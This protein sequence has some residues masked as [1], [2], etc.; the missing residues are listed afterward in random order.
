MANTAN[1][2]LKAAP[3]GCAVSAL[4]VILIWAFRGLSLSTVA[5]S[6]I[7]GILAF[8]FMLAYWRTKIAWFCGMPFVAVLVPCIVGG[9]FWNI[10]SGILIALFFQ[11]M[12][13]LMFGRA[14]V[15]WTSR[16]R[17]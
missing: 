1:E 7:A 2:S 6:P 3:L 11:Y 16:G 10:L 14:L 5:I 12:P 8:A 17:G 4:G 13:L 9:G 15:S